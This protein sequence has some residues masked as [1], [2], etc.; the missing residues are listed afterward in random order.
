MTPRLETER[1]SLVP[2]RSDDVRE[3][4]SVLADPGLYAFIGGC[5]PTSEELS[6]RYRAWGAGSP[7]PGEVWHNW[8]IRERGGGD[9]VGHLQA[10]V[11]EARRSA[12]VGWLVGMAWQSRGYATEAAGAL[13]GWLEA[14]GVTSITALV[15]PGNLASARVAERAGFEPT[16]D[17]VDG[18]VAWRRIAP[19]G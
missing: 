13:V 15:H 18:E 2:L 3:M 16:K 11:L 6:A 7:R 19:P 5:P 10:T 17:I 12:D 9:A 4:V 1:L 8:V 14:G